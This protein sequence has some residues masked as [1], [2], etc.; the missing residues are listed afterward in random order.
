MALLIYLLENPGRVVDKEE[1]IAAVWPK[2]IVT[3]DS[4]SQC[5][6]DIRVALGSAAEGFI[7]TVPRRGYILDAENVQSRSRLPAHP[8]EKPTIQPRARTDQGVS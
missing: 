5:L 8:S 4:L 2:T 3:D 7:R 6:K 1:L